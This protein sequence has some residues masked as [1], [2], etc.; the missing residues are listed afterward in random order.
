MV[1]ITVLK[2]AMLVVFLVLLQVVYHFIMKKWLGIT[3]KYTF[4]YVNDLHRTMDWSIRGIFIAMLLINYVLQW[5]GLLQWGLIIFFVALG[6][7]RTI[8]QYKNQDGSNL[9]K[10]TASHV[11]FIVAI[12]PVM[13]LSINYWIA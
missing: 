13:L 5:I 3:E 1:M 6:L 9:Y 11:V 10:L 12:Y 7:L 2:A 4:T 8:M